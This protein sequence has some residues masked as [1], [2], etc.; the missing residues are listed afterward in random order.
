MDVSPYDSMQPAMSR[1][2]MASGL[3]QVHTWSITRVCP[4]ASC[5][6]HKAFHAAL[7]WWAASSMITCRLIMGT[8]VFIAPRHSWSVHSEDLLR[9]FPGLARLL[10]VD[11]LKGHRLFCCHCCDSLLIG[12]ESR[13]GSP[14][15]RLTLQLF[16][17]WRIETLLTLN[18]ESRD[19]Q[20]SKETNWSQHTSWSAQPIQ[21]VSHST[22]RSQ[23][24]Q[25]L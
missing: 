16:L 1:A 10:S 7:L 9:G 21:T 25:G 2:W 3:A 12:L 24:Y 5:I 15:T 8:I 4:C 11:S 14:P 18:R 20:P 17:G 22:P 19:S 6:T 23:S 13:S